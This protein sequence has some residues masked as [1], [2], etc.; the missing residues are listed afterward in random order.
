MPLYRATATTLANLV[1]EDTTTGGFVKDDQVDDLASGFLYGLTLANNTGDATNDLDIAAGKCIDSTNAVLMTLSALTKRLDADWTAGTGN[2]MRNTTAIADT[3][4]HI[5]AVCKAAGAD[6]DIF[7]LGNSQG[8]TAAQAIT[9]LQAMTGGSA[10]AYARRIGS[11]VRATSIKP[12]RQYGDR[13]VWESPALDVNATNPGATAVTATLTLPL[14][15]Q[16]EADLLVAARGNTNNFH[17][18]ISD[19]A[20]ADVT[21]TSTIR[22]AMSVTSGAGQAVSL[23]VPVRVRTN[24]SAQVRYRL[25]A[26]GADDTF[27]INTL[28]WIDT[29]GRLA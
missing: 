24:T 29:R 10:Y 9:A 19:P 3:T 11:I 15:L 7:A 12:F 17:A 5:F 20:Q 16:I 13:F 2:G 4:Y 8:T 18:Y 22:N 1:A 27:S 14:G 25:S 23:P 6:P 28:G 21:P 26:S